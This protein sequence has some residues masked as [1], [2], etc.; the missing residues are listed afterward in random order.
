MW[1]QSWQCY[2]V[3]YG[4]FITSS[5]FFIEMGTLSGEAAL[6]YLFLSPFFNPLYTGRLSHC[7]MLNKSIC[8]A[9]GVQSILSILFDF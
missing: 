4:K 5:S 7:Y 6:S 9:R 1:G 8:H 3:Q 2:A